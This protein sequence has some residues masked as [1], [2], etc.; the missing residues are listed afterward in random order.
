MCIHLIWPHSLIKHLYLSD[1]WQ[2]LKSIWGMGAQKTWGTKHI[3]V[4]F[5]AA[6]KKKRK[7]K[8]KSFLIGLSLIWSNIKCSSKLL[9]SLSL[10][11][12]LGDANGPPSNFRMVAIIYG[13]EGT[14]WMHPFMSNCDIRYVGVIWFIFH[15]LQFNQLN[16]QN[17]GR[18]ALA[19]LQQKICKKL[20]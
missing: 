1:I 16:L 12:S 11:L 5:R 13:C 10:S 3:I 6:T 14:W 17:K 9:D 8:K 7:E 18:I 2:G 15:S 20:D 4:I 19:K